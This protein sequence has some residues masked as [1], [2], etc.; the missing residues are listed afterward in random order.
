MPWDD[1]KNYYWNELGVL[2]AVNAFGNH[3]ILSKDHF[4]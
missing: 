4:S 3:Y 2:A 1:F